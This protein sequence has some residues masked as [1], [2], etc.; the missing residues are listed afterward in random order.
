MPCGTLTGPSGFFLY[1]GFAEPPPS[2]NRWTPGTQ[3]LA[4]SGERSYLNIFVYVLLGPIITW[5]AD[6]SPAW[7]G[8]PVIEQA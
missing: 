3:H 2:T 7:F 4:R 6:L 1:S 5:G 8:S